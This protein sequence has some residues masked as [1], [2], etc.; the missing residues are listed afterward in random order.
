MTHKSVLDSSRRRFLQVTLALSAGA[1]GVGCASTSVRAGGRVVVIGGGFGGA[2]AA[3]YLRLWSQGSIEVTLVERNVSFISCPLSNLVIAG[4]LPITE[5]IRS[6]DGLKKHGVRVIQGEVTAIDGERRE[7]RLASSEVLGY[8]RLV[9]APGIDFMFDAVPGLT[10][11]ISETRILHAFKAGPQTVGLRKQLEQMPDGGVFALCVPKVPYRC[12]PAPYER[13]S[14]VAHYFKNNKPKSKVLILDANPD[15]AS[16]KGLFEHEWR[17]HL[18]DH[19]E[20]RADHQITQLDA[21]Q[22]TLR[23]SMGETVKADVINLIP[24]HSAGALARNAGLANEGGRW[25][26]VDW[27]SFESTV[28]KNIH[29]IGDATQAAPAMPK[30]GTMANTAGKVVAAA[31]VN[32]LAQRPLNPA[33]VLTNVCY[34]FFDPGNV[35]HMVSVHPY[36]PKE[37]TY[38][39]VVGAGGL[40][41]APN[42]LEAKFA[43]AWAKNIWADTL[44]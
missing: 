23:F 22:R 33:P 14:L 28:A 26:G 41:T 38:M 34:S 5:L 25:C 29:V 24:P 9:V 27:L 44:D 2:T 17:E 32:L 4:N 18:N 1:G 3:K 31:I 43:M 13:A 30:S 19:L 20:H 21:A 16:K 35:A 39:P 7:V 10:R 42:E 6:Y 12:P 40:S 36:D 37:K 8:D 15:I 11:E